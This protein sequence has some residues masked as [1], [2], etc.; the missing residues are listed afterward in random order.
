MAFVYDYGGQI[1][2]RKGGKWKGTLNTPNALAG[3]TQVKAVFK[4]LSRASR[5]G[6]EANPQQALVFAKGKVASFP[7]N[8]WEWPYALDDKL[9]NPALAPAIGAY[10]MPSHVAGRYMPGFLGGSDLAIPITSKDVSLS[11]DWIKAFTSTA[12]QRALVTQG[13]VIPNTTSLASIAASN[14]QLAPFAQAAKS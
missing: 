1:A 14:P 7:G 2:V 12:S 11:A 4:Q 9:G 5:T 10:P 6:D 8:G 3:L 13:K